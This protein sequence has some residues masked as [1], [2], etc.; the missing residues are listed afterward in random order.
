MQ[1]VETVFEMRR[2][3]A[4]LNSSGRKIALVPTSGALHPG[5]AAL[6]A[7][8]K[9]KAEVVVVAVFPNP[10][11]FGPSEN[12]S[13]YPRSLESDVELC[14]ELGVEV[15]FLPAVDEMFPRGY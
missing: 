13:R 6:I 3:A 11:A 7:A 15:V 12:F 4:Q 9:A 14:R 2:V 10:L 8:A 5:H 1:K